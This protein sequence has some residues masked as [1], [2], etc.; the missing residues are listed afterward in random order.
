MT[1]LRGAR[2]RLRAL[3][4]RS[5]WLRAAMAALL[6]LSAALVAT[7][8]LRRAEARLAA[9]FEPVE[10]VVASRAI[11]AGRPL[12][13]A[14]LRTAPLP[15]ASLPGSALVPAAIPELVGR[16]LALPLAP[17]DP[18]L[19]SLVGDLQAPRPLAADLAVGRRAVAVPIDAASAVAGFVEPGDLVDVVLVWRDAAG[20]GRAATLLEAVGVLAV[21]DRRQPGGAPNEGG[22][23]VLETSPREAEALLVA[24]DQGRLALVLRAAGD[25]ASRPDRRPVTL[26]PLLPGFRT[27]AD[28]GPG[29]EVIRGAR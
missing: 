11:D 14:D 13:A 25:R 21:G 16:R 2:E 10:V 19:L 6:A 4:E 28:R 23:A 15:R 17:G 12:A 5:P 18:V 27:P 1:T 22:T 20:E 8:Y 9:R 24:M 7:W 3:A 26:P 29:V